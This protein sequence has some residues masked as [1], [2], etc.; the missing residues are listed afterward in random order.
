MQQE[1]GFDLVS[2]D[3]ADKNGFIEDVITNSR[4]GA[5]SNA[6]GYAATYLAAYGNWEANGS[7]RFTADP[8]TVDG[9]EELIQWV[10]HCGIDAV[11]DPRDCAPESECHPELPVYQVSPNHWGIT[12]FTR[13]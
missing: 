11:V 13:R 4:H 6:R 9:P 8:G 5:G 10:T 1:T 2:A 3:F 12:V 7:P